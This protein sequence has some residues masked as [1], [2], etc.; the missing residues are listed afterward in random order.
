VSSGFSLGSCNWVLKADGKKV[1]YVTSSSTL[2]TH[3]SPME[4]SALKDSDIFILAGLT[5][6]PTHNPDTMMGEICMTVVNTLRGGG[7]VVF[8]CYPSGIIYDLFECLANHL[9]SS[10]YGNYPFY[11]IAPHSETSLAYSNILA[12]WLSNSKQRRVYIPEDPFTHAE[13][14]KIGRLKHYKTLHDIPEV[15]QPCILFCGHPCLRFGDIVHV[16]E[17]WGSNHANTI[18]FTEAEFS[19]I[20]CLI[21]YQ[22][23]AMKTLYC[24]I[25]TSLNFHQANK[26]IKD[27]KPSLLVTQE[28]YL[29]P[30]KNHP[31]RIELIID[32][33]AVEKLATGSFVSL[34]LNRQSVNSL[35]DPKMAR[36]VDPT[37]RRGNGNGIFAST[38]TANLDNTDN[39][40]RL[41]KPSTDLC[42]PLLY[43]AK[44][45]T[46]GQ[47]D[48][49][50][51]LQKLNQEGF[52]QAKLQT[53]ST[54][55]GF[56]IS[57]PA[58]K[59]TITV[60]GTSTHLS[61]SSEDS[62]AIRLKLRRILTSCLTEF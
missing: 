27:L 15:R 23:L 24:P 45:Y 51:I 37:A 9:D 30:P 46:W 48:S 53:N 6:A 41:I 26:L 39:K 2:T 47:L 3:P 1:A 61:C 36:D 4:Q 22:P 29:V 34:K 16:I 20:E 43:P 31:H 50:Q 13:L 49:T 42:D 56:V 10:G 38:I 7:N 40:N 62:G 55:N 44:K 35:M 57:L 18:I 19:Y 8:P 52:S 54:S 12:E 33:P 58:E 59:A 11:F 14:V 32:Y 28:E 17:S 60:E 5:Q 25:D 21:P